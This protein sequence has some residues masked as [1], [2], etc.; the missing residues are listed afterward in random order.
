MFDLVFFEVGERD[1]YKFKF[2]GMFFVGINKLDILWFF[3]NCVCNFL[4][5]EK[6]VF[7]EL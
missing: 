1:I 7:M 3:V 6:F 2:F 5:E 4:K